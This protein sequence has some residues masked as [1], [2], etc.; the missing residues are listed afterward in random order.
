MMNLS[1]F[2]HLTQHQHALLNRGLSFIPTKTATTNA[3]QELAFDL[4]KYHRRL[5][6]SAHF[7]S[8]P[9]TTIS[10]FTNPSDWEPR[11]E[12][13]PTEL[14]ELIHLDGQH[15]SRLKY[16][17]ET[18]NL[19]PAEE[20]AL[21]SLI[22]TRGIVIKPADK[23]S[24]TVIMDKADYVTEA[25]RQLHDSQYYTP[26]TEPIYT[27]T[28]LLIAEELQ[29]L[30]SAKYI[31]RRQLQYLKGQTP[32]RPR[33]F[34]LLPKIHKAMEKWTIPQHMPPGRPIVSDCGSE[35]Y[36]I[37]EYLDYF[38][39]PLST[40][41]G[42]YVKDTQHFLDRVIALTL[43]EPCFLFTMDVNSLYTN[44]EIPLGMEA[45]KKIL[46]RYPDPKRPDEILMKL[47]DISLTRNDFV[48]QDKFYLQT[49]GTAM[50]KR[51]APAYANIYMADWEETAFLK[52]KLLPKIYIRYLDDI[53]GIWTHSKEDFE[54]FVQ[55]LNSHHAS[56]KVEPEL[57]DTEV[58]FLDTTIFKGPDFQ[59]TGK[60]DAKLYIK[61]TDNHALLHKNSFHPKHVF[62]GILK[63]QLL[64]FSRICTRVQDRNEAR[65]EL[66][67]ALRKRGYSRGFLRRAL[68]TEC[69][70][71]G[72]KDHRQ[73][74]PLV[75]TYSTGG[76]RASRM[77]NNNFENILMNSPLSQTF[78]MLPAFRKNPNLQQLLVRAKLPTTAKTSPRINA[79]Q[80]V[81]NRSTGFVHELPKHIPRTQN[82]CVYALKCTKCRKLYIGETRNQLNDRLT[83]HKYV[84]RTSDSPTS[85][86][87]A[88]FQK[89]GLQNLIARP[90]EHDPTWTV[91]QRR[92]REM[93][94]IRQLDTYHP[95]GL[96]DRRPC[97]TA[98]ET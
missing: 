61:P 67:R 50:G 3:R 15:L 29:K 42:S 25:L 30:L 68:Q 33:Y 84:I 17:P 43:T 88:H 69:V 6:L 63:S 72:A 92:K 2:F 39:T 9:E 51:F 22:K 58:H 85:S 79:W 53:W 54:V 28:A 74:I 31:S 21:D 45:I 80:T 20:A 62:T 41:H 7:R 64:R 18:P 49:K 1:R 71:N 36:G 70:S 87:V 19:P 55:T 95:R 93:Y 82:N 66:F 40:K 12:Q 34:Y 75:L 73:K 47:L 26:L 83:Q 56:I 65:R 98:T 89:H 91:F 5:K 96:N 14:L 90:L 76:K 8:K 59:S 86:L 13:L 52:C 37:A 60:L 4:K 23:G 44:I 38:L 77:L 32:P 35:S 78:R 46:R 57:N 48:F 16:T 81:R 27:E 24:V 94:W 97:M 10:P 11:P